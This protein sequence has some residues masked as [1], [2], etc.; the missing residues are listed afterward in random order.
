[1]EY[2]LGFLF[3]FLTNYINYSLRDEKSS[4]LNLKSREPTTVTGTENSL[5]I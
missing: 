4:S 5:H 1:M 3:P 2:E